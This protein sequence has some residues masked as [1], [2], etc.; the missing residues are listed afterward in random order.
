MSAWTP[1]LENPIAPKTQ[2]LRGRPR[3]PQQ[4]NR[5]HIYLPESLTAR[6]EEIQQ[7]CHA[8]SLTE[9]VKLSLIHI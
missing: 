4:G 8:S 3:N 6:L 7:Y 9:V 1:E 5:L 2:R